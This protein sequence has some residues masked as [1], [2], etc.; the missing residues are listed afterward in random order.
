MIQQESAVPIF[1]DRINALITALKEFRGS[2]GLTPI[3]PTELLFGMQLNYQH[4]TVTNKAAEEVLYKAQPHI[5]GCI[6][7]KTQTYII[8]SGTG[9]FL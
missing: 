8:C 3:L 2:F 4:G 7:H 9:W 5:K 1:V 6:M